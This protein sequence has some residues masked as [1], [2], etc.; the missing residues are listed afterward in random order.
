MFSSCVS[1]TLNTTSSTSMPDNEVYAEIK[2]IAGELKDG[3]DSA[4]Y[5]MLVEKSAVF[6]L[7]FVGEILIKCCYKQI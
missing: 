3:S 7:V 5:E 1:S 2:A 6:N 4:A